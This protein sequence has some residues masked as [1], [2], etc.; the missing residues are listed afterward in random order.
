[1][2]QFYYIVLRGEFAGVA[3]KCVTTAGQSIV[4]S[5]VLHLSRDKFVPAFLM[6]IRCVMLDAVAVCS[7]SLV[8]NVASGCS[9]A[10]SCT[11]AA[12]QGQGETLFHLFPSFTSSFSFFLSSQRQDPAPG[13]CLLDPSK[14]CFCCANFL[15]D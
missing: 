8:A 5:Y 13:A 9:S 14:H 10:G 4:L 15:P 11:N 6:L 3:V 7:D 2:V 12:H 1:M